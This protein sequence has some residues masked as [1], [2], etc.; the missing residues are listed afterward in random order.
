MLRLRRRNCDA[1]AGV[2]SAYDRQIVGT[3]RTRRSLPARAAPA[4]SPIRRRR[5]SVLMPTACRLKTEQQ[6]SFKR[7]AAPVIAS[8]HRRHA[9]RAGTR[10]S[11]TRGKVNGRQRIRE[12]SVAARPARGRRQANLAH[13]VRG[14]KSRSDREVRPDTGALPVATIDELTD[15]RRRHDA[16]AFARVSP[17]A[18]KR[19]L[20]PC[21]G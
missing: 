11:S 15:G 14:N 12:G 7:R 18:G 5:C 8:R 17:V 19:S 3:R 21:R 6:L 13:R 16:E 4:S 20:A 1:R 10:A 2:N 9:L